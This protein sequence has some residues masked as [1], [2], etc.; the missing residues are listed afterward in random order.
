MPQVIAVIKDQ[1]QSIST[2]LKYV[3]KTTVLVLKF[4]SLTLRVIRLHTILLLLL[5]IYAFIYLHTEM[6]I[7]VFV[8]RLYAIGGR[9]HAVDGRLNVARIYIGRA[10]R[11]VSKNFNLHEFTYDGLKIPKGFIH[12]IANMAKEAILETIT[13]FH[14]VLPETGVRVPVFMECQSSKQ[15]SPL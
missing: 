6:L 10:P 2:T 9:E 7:F 5:F 13:D 12:F 1:L 4:S 3:I 8:F 14:A 15:I 11:S